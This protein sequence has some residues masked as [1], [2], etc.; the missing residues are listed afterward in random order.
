MRQS[1]KMRMKSFMKRVS[2]ICKTLYRLVTK[3]H[4]RIEIRQRNNDIWSAYI[5][6]ISPSGKHHLDSIITEDNLNS[7]YIRVFKKLKNLDKN[8]MIE[9]AL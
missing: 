2:I 5:Y 1:L 6:N 3:D 7:V 4:I 9:V 8:K